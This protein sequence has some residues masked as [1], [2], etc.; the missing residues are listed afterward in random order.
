MLSKVE[1]NNRK[2][3]KQLISKFAEYFDVSTKDLIIAF[4]SD[5]IA[6]QVLEDLDLSN[7]IFKAAEG[8]VNYLKN[9]K[10]SRV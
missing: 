8:K 5:E 3:S 9:K 6:Y 1:K 2:P 7:K 10:K 4:L